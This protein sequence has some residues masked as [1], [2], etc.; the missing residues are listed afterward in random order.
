VIQILRQRWDLGR[1]LGRDAEAPNLVLL[2]PWISGNTVVGQAFAMVSLVKQLGQP[3]P[4][5]KHPDEQRTQTLVRDAV[6][7]PFPRLGSSN[8]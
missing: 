5:I 8:P 3:A 2:P 4:P 1:P 7:H 6:S